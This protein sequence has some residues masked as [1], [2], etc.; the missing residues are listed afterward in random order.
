MTSMGKL[1]EGKPRLQW[2][3]PMVIGVQV[4]EH[5]NLYETWKGRLPVA[6]RNKTFVQII[7]VKRLSI[8]FDLLPY[9]KVCILKFFPPSMINLKVIKPLCLEFFCDRKSN[10]QP[11]LEVT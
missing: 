8:F 6:K 11:F 4:L 2:P 10:L 5:P 1:K 3:P 9:R 7:G